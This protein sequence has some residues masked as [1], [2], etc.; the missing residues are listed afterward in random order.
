MM[1]VDPAA[2]PAAGMTVGEELLYLLVY[3]LEF[4]ADELRDPELAL[5]HYAAMEWDRIWSPETFAL[6]P[7]YLFMMLEVGRRSSFTCSAP[8]CAPPRTHLRF[9]CRC[10]RMT[11][12]RGKV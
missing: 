4:L 12:T 10:C 7:I 1:A 3:F 6:A 2:D 11:K 9:L 5:K 8:C